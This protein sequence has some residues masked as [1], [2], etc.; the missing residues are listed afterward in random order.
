MELRGSL[1]PKPCYNPRTLG[2]LKPFFR[3]F[4][5]QRRRGFHSTHTRTHSFFVIISSPFLTPA[6]TRRSGR[7]N[8]GRTEH[9]QTTGK[10]NGTGV[11]ENSVE[12]REWAW[13]LSEGKCLEMDFWTIIKWWGCFFLSF[14]I[15][16]FLFSRNLYLYDR[17]TG[18]NNEIINQMIIINVGIGGGGG[19]GR[20]NNKG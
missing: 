12:K 9:S 4:Q 1:L 2:P 15:S 13:K 14:A 3:H 20:Q 17:E 8:V 18:D 16:F 7:E 10:V 5:I 11:E 19:R 6:S